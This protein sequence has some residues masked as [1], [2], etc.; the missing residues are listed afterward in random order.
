[1]NTG[2]PLLH[3]CQII[4]HQYLQSQ[5]PTISKHLLTFHLQLVAKHSQI[6]LF[7]GKLEFVGV[8]KIFFDLI[9]SDPQ[10][11]NYGKQT[12]TCGWFAENLSRTWFLCQVLGWALAWRGTRVRRGEGGTK[13]FCNYFFQF[14]AASST[15]CQRTE[16]FTTQQNTAGCKEGRDQEIQYNLGGILILVEKI[17]LGSG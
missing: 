16:V 14:A 8:L 5:T 6:N 15:V 11:T 9:I 2:P 7:V 10:Q 12:K 17:W 13:Y 3:H 1:M 4:H